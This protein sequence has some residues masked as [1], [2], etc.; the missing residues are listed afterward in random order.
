MDGQTHVKQYVQD[1]KYKLCDKSCINC[2][3]TH[4]NQNSLKKNQPTSAELVRVFRPPS[5][6]VIKSMYFG[7][8]FCFIYINSGC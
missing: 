2:T 1:L 3:W 5:G 6:L 4:R 8:R 7:L